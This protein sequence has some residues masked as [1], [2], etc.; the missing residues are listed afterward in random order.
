M[1]ATE[2]RLTA[3]LAATAAMVREE[4]LRPLT[5][6]RRRPRR[7]LRAAA[8]LAA[9]AAVAAVLGAEIGIVHFGGAARPAAQAGAT[10]SV[11]RFPSG[12]AFDAA[13]G[14]L[15]I[16]SRRRGLTM[17]NA[18]AC[19]ASSLRGCA[20]VR[21]TASGGPQ[22]L[23]IAIDDRTRTAYVADAPG[24]VTVLNT[25]TCNAAAKRCPAAAA[26][27]TV[28]GTPAALAVNPRTDTIYVLGIRP[29]QMWVI[30][31]GACNA[32]DTSGCATALTAARLPATTL[33]VPAIAVDPATNTLYLATS[34]G[35]AVIDGRTCAATTV[36]GCAKAAG[37]VPMGGG[38][39]VDIAVDDGTGTIYATNSGFG[40]IAVIDRNTCD[41]LDTSGCRRLRLVRGGPGP[42]ELAVNG[43]AHTLYVTN[44]TNSV[45]M[46]NTAACGAA[47]VRRCSQFPASFPVGRY[48]GWIAAD[49]AAHTV[50]VVNDGA[51][52]V[53]VIDSAACNALDTR[54]CPAKSPPGTRGIRQ[55]AYTCDG[56]LS[57]YVS[58]EPAR[59][60]M[61]ASVRVAAGSA[62]GRPW[63]LWAKRG[64]PD[65]NGIEQGGL[66]LNGRWYALCDSELSAGPEA[67][68][69]LIDAGA[70]GVVYGFI[71]HPVRVTIRLRA[72]GVAPWAPSSVLLP[73]TTF[74]IASL[75]RSACS[76]HA[77]RVGAW[78][79][80]WGGVSN[81]TFGLCVT[82]RLV[83]SEQ[84]IGEWGPG[85]GSTARSALRPP[86]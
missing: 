27:V 51:G 30:N 69:E 61:R 38:Y 66:V 84:G 71:Q 21:H 5:V 16:D 53:S 74:F 7:W 44:A 6:P 35:V 64:V 79:G 52:T 28:P 85:A 59:R 1:T 24:A 4:T 13:S 57:N 65:P 58:G 11:G 75:P 60:L 31:G 48:P 36:E 23:A 45:S 14:T 83:A 32:S 22:P 37:I 56:P 12:I 17:I 15:Y 49:P 70:H 33:P 81:R 55:T 19:N 77:L 40:V 80:T 67:N 26:R 43:P 76:Y 72:P 68:F 8:P 10:V 78:Q 3:A 54:G 18:A 42:A 41:S 34:G 46:V 82:G 50:Y 47:G 9:A 62:G 39:L 73:G 2:N 25:A 20:R 63:S 86:R 29:G